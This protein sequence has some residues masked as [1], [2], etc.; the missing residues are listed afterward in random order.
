MIFGPEGFMPCYASEG[1]GHTAIYLSS[2]GAWDSHL[3]SSAGTLIR[4]A[5]STLVR[6]SVVTFDALS[7]Q[8]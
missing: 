4:P 8:V 6:G 2:F 5:R 3:L 7:W 1:Y